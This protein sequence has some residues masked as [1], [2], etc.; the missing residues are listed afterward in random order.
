VILFTDISEDEKI[1]LHTQ[2]LEQRAVLGEVTAVFAHEVRNP[3]NN[4]ATGLQLLG[5]LQE[6][7]DSK[8]ELISRMLGDCNRLNHLME[9]VLAFSRPIETRFEKI[10]LPSLL[11]KILDRWRP[12][13]SKLNI[14][15][16]IKRPD[17]SREIMG[18]PRALEQVFTNL[19]SN[20]VEAMSV[21][22]GTL[23]IQIIS[24]ESTPARPKMIVELSDTGPGIP[25]EMRDRIFEPFVT[26]S[27]RGTG[28]GLA[29]TK[30]I[31]T[32]HRGTVI[33]D[34]FP[35]GTIFKVSFPAE[36]GD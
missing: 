31:V 17:E 19:I 23:G 35:G 14:I 7:D 26:A 13:F 32:A 30:R 8:Q 1:K 10:D 5:T 29:I 27:P 21:N 22:G 18:D 20:S 12:R 34:T 6:P 9:S 11:Q 33:L 4:I 28:L 25:P 2:H 24:D 36:I 16:F 3:I 15:P